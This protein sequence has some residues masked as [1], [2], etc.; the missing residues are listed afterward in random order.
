MLK[1]ARP[2]GMPQQFALPASSWRHFETV[3]DFPQGLVPIGDAVCRFNPIYGQGMSVAAREASI[4]AALLRGR[5][6][7]GG[8]AGLPQDYLA[9]VQPWIAGAWSMSATPDLAYPQTRGERPNDLEDRLGFAAGL[10]RLAARDP[11]VH[12]AL[13]SVRHIKRPDDALREPGLVARIRAEME[14][15]SIQPAA[16]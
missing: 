15:A 9:A 4:L 7:H 13:I 10:Y 14:A 16:A 11:A 12:K 6:H 3:V 1:N 5:A 8:L 2:A